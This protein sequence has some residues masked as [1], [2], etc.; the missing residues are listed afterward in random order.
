MAVALLVALALPGVTL[1]GGVTVELDEPLDDVE[2]GKPLAIGFTIRSAHEDRQLITGL[3]P[4]LILTNAD[5]GERV[6]AVAEPDGKAG[7]YLASVTLP[8]RGEWRWRVAPF[9]KQDLGYQLTMAPFGARGAG[10][11]TLAKK[12]PSGKQLAANAG[13]NFFEPRDLSVEAGTTITWKNTGKLPHTVTAADDSFASGNML[14]GDSFSWTFDEPGT[15]KYF[16][17][18]HAARPVGSAAGIQPVVY[19]GRASYGGGMHMLGMVVVRPAAKSAEAAAPEAAKSTDAK[20]NEAV[21]A[22]AEVQA[23]QAAAAEPAAAQETSASLPA[24]GATGL[25][26]I[27]LATFAVVVVGAGLLLRRRL[28]DRA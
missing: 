3:I 6:E 4:L 10:E 22:Q 25:P 21:L 9:G 18:Y 15:F 20:A 12:A 27:I 1:A 2:A 5:T 14:P 26:Y 16:C 8:S 7:H 13:D 23:P 11:S 28:I 19:S 17:E 24:T